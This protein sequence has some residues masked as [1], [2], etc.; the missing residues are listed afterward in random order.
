MAYDVVVVGAGIVGCAAAAFLARGGARVAVFDAGPVGAGASG[1]NAGFVEHPFDREQVA[2]HDETVAL[3][4]DALGDAMPGAPTGILLLCADERGVERALVDAAPHP[5]LAPRALSPEE[6]AALEPGVREGLWGCLLATGHPLRPAEAVR[7]FADLA[8]A[9]GATI[10]TDAPAALWWEDGVV[11]GVVAGG[12]ACRADVV[13]VA[14]GAWSS[15]LVD[16]TLRWRPVRPLWGVSVALGAERRPRVP[17]IDGRGEGAEPMVFSLI[18]TPDELALG[19]TW[20]DDEPDG[21]TWAPRLRAEAAAFWPPAADA[22]VADVRVCAR[23]HAFD[24]RPLLG[25]VAGHRT[26]WIAAGHGGRGISTGA[27]SA[28]LVADAILAGTD[29][30]VPPALRADRFGP[31]PRA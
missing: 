29:R 2:L 14:A 6:V 27:A 13:L 31:P 20:L 21:A 1:R 10:A 8:R 11:R 16:P 3:L 22:V 23:P 9:R 5:E 28:R 4:R 12:E 15:A 25:R 18:P 17:L 19:S 26:L 30:D 24:G 7:R